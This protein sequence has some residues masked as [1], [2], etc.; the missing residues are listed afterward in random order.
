M[1]MA[2]TGARVVSPATRPSAAS[3]AIADAR[4]RLRVKTEFK[5]NKSAGVVR[6][7]FF[8]AVS[9]FAF[10]VRALVVDKNR[11]Y[12]EELRTHADNFYATLCA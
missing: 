9:P 2:Q 12:S 4:L 11:I 1:A 8:E 5:F 3:K 10:G 6:D 7:G